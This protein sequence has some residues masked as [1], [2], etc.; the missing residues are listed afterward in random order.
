MNALLPID[1]GR[2][3]PLT[4]VDVNANVKKVLRSLQTI[5]DYDIALSF[6]VKGNLRDAQRIEIKLRPKIA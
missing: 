6:D 3:W 2:L 5:V 1:R 4:E